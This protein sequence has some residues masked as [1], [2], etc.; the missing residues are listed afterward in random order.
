MA[1]GT[2]VDIILNPMGALRMNLGQVLEAHLGLA[3]LWGFEKDGVTTRARPRVDAG[4]R[5]ARENE[6][7]VDPVEAQPRRH[8]DGRRRRQSLLYDGRSG[9]PYAEPVTVGVSYI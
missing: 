6:I 4:V 7:R 9:E 8:Q 3:A 2:P 1:D 5:R